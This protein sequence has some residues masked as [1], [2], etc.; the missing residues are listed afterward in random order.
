MNIALI[1]VDNNPNYPNLS[2]MKLSAWHKSQGDYVQL[3]SAMDY[4]E[5]DLF[6]EWDKA[7]AACVFSWNCKK[8][9]ILAKHGAIVGG[10]GYDMSSR[11]PDEVEHIMPDYSLYGITDTAYGFYPVAVRGNAHSVS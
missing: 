8:A 10:S 3:I 9:R 4:L 2:L 7:Y 1:D 11:L 5:R 6:V